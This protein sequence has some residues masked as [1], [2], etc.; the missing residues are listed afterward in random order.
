MSGKNV[1]PLQLTTKEFLLVVCA[2][3]DQDTLIETM[4]AEEYLRVSEVVLGEGDLEAY[5][6]ARHTL[7]KKL[8]YNLRESA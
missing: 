6:E 1:L 5:S 3:H 8:L 7:K 2:V 4:G